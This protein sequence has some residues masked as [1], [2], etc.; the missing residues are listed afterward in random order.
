[1]LRRFSRLLLGPCILLLAAHGA[2]RGQAAL[3][4][5]FADQIVTGGLDYPVGIAF[6]PD[7]RLLVAEQVSAK[8]KLVIGASSATVTTIGTVAGVNTSGPERGL[9]GLAV[10]PLWPARPYLYVHSTQTGTPFVVQIS[11]FTLS[12]DLSFTGSGQLTLDPASRY[13]LINTF[14]ETPRHNGGTLRFGLDGMLYVS[15]GEDGTSCAAQ[16]TTSTTVSRGVILRLDVSRL[17]SGPGSASLALLTPAD[18]PFVATGNPRTRLIWALGLRNPFRFHIDP[19]NGR[20]FI[21]D[22][23]GALQEEID[24]ADHGAYD[25]GWPLY[26]GTGPG[27]D[28]S[29]PPPITP[30]GPIYAYDRTSQSEAAVIGAGVYRHRSGATVSFPSAYEGD[31]FF[32]D[33]YNGI[34]TRLE[35]NGST[36][37]IAPAVAGQPAA[38]HWAEGLDAVSDYLEGYDGAIWYCRQAVGTAGAGSGE[39]RRIAFTSGTPD[40]TIDTVRTV[41]VEMAD[42]YPLPVFHVQISFAY[43]LSASARVEMDLYDVRGRLVRRLLA[44]GLQPAGPHT[45]NWDGRDQDGRSV[46]AGLYFVRLSVN[47]KFFERRV[48]LIR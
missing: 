41:L 13:D 38:T 27:V 20:V 32:S 35:Q 18:N 4:D 37:S 25:F 1:M 48:P 22:V 40:T 9:L 24:L 39:I 11:R 6:L 23:G 45:E 14:D 16:D 2:A 12:G 30:T 17:P 29:C 34:L 31:Y 47:G 8:I 33:Y 28:M 3:P 5:G 15:I 42:P 43:T 44:P 10:D 21:G 7:H 19:S 26:E 36:W 46:P